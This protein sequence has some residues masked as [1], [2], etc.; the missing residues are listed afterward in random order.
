M[1]RPLR[2]FLPLAAALSSFLASSQRV[3]AQC[4]VV[5]ESIVV[6]DVTCFGAND[7]SISITVSGGFP[8]YNYVLTNGPLFISSGPQATNTF[9]FSGL[10]SGVSDYQVIVVGEDGI[11]GSCLG[12][13]GLAVINDPAPFDI[14]LTTTDKSC[15]DINDGS[16]SVVVT[17]GA[18]PYNYAW[19]PFPVTVDNISGLDSGT[20]D[21]VVTDA[22]GCSETVP[23]T[24]NQEPDWDGTLTATP[25]TC[26]NGSDG[27]ILSSGITGGTP[28]YNFS[29]S[30]GGF[31]T[32]SITD[33]TAG[34]YTLTVT[35]DI[36][37][38]F[39]PTP[40]VISEP[41]PISVTG[42]VTDVSC[43]GLQDGEIDLTVSG[44]TPPYTF[45]WSNGSTTEDLVGLTGGFYIVTVLDDNGCAGA[46]PFTIL[47]G[48]TVN[49]GFLITN[50]ECNESNG[51]VSLNVTGGSGNYS[52]DWQPGGQTTQ[53]VSGLPQGIYS[54]TVT[55]NTL[56]CSDDLFLF[57]NNIP[58]HTVDGVVTD[59]SSCVANDGAIDIT[60]NGGSGNFDYSWSPG[61]ETTQDL[62]NLA[63]GSYNVTVTDNVEGCVVVE[64]FTV[65]TLSNVIVQV[66]VVQ[67]SCG[68]PNGSIILNVSG[69]TDPYTFLWSNGSTDQNLV[70]V[71]AGIYQVIITDVNGC[72][73]DFVLVLDDDGTPDVTSVVSNPSCSNSAD[74]S[75]TLSL[76]GGVGPFT[77]SWSNGSI[78]QSI[79]NLTAGTYSVTILDEGTGCLTFETFDLISPAALGG[80]A[81]ITPVTCNG[82]A[83]G[84][85]DITIIGGTAPYDIVWNPGNISAPSISGL[86]GGTYQ[87]TITDDNGCQI[88]G[89][90]VVDEPA[91]LTLST[92]SVNISCD[93]SVPGSIDLNVS[94]GTGPYTYNWSNGQITEDIGGLTEGLYVVNVTDA[95]GC[96]ASTAVSIIQNDRLTATS[97]SSSAECGESNGSVFLDVTGGSGN[98]SF[99]W[100]PGGQTAQ[101]L[102]DVAAGIYTVT[103]TDLDLGCDETLFILVNNF[104]GHDLQ[105]TVT[106]GTDC[107]SDDGAI[108]LTINGGSG[109]FN[110]LWTPGGETTE[111]ISGLA[112]GSYLV[113]VEDNVTG[114]LVFGSYDVNAA[115][116]TE[117]IATVTDPTCGATDGSIA[118]S[119]TNGNGPFT[120]Q[121]S[122]GATVDNISG[123]A[124]GI[125]SLTVTDANGC[126]LDTLFTLSGGDAPDLT[127]DV[128]GPDCS[129]T[130]NGSIS[131]TP[132]G[133]TGPFTYQWS[134]GATSSSITNLG[135]GT[136][137]VVVTDQ[138]TGCQAFGTYSITAPPPLS[139]SV[140]IQ[141]VVCNGDDT[142]GVFV[143]ILGGTAPYTYL[144][145]P[146][147]STDQNLTGVPG[148]TYQV[149]VTDANGCSIFGQ[150]N[151]NEADAI[152]ISLNVTDV[153]CAGGSDGAIDM[154][155]NG[156]T[157]PFTYQWFPGGQTTEDINNLPAGDYS[158]VVTDAN[159]C[160]SSQIVLGGT[161][162]GGQLALPDGNGVS[163]NTTIDI[164]GFPANETIQTGTD[165]EEMCVNIEHSYL[166]DLE[167]RLICPS[168][169]S[170][171]LKPQPGGL[172]TY[173]GA[174]NDT[175]GGG[176][177]A[178]TGFDYCF[179]MNA[180]LGTILQEN[181]NGNWVTAGNPPNN[182]M[183]PGTYTPDQSFDN[184]IGCPLNGTWTLQVTDN[185]SIDDGFV[186]DWNVSFSGSGSNDSLAIVNEPDP[187]DITTNN[188]PATCGVCDGSITVS[189][190]NGTAP[191]TYLWNT[192]ATTATLNNICAGI[193]QVLVTDANGCVQ[194]F[195]LAL[196]NVTGPVTGGA[197]IT[198]ATCFNSCDGEATINPSGGTPPYTYQWVPGGQNTNSVSSLC[199]GDY[200]VQVQ[201]ADGC[202]STENVTIG[203]PP[204]IQVGRTVTNSTCGQC[205]GT[206]N[207]TPIAGPEP[208]SYD[209]SPAVV[210]NQTSA[211]DLCAGVYNITVTDAT[212]CE[213]VVTVLLNDFPAATLATT[214]TAPS[215]ETAC[216]GEATVT[217]I[218][219]TPPYFYVWND[220]LAQTNNTAINL[221]AGT[222]G[223]TVTDSD[224]CTSVAQVDLTAPAPI[225]LSLLIVDN[226]VCANDCDGAITV[227]PSGGTI[228]FTYL[229]SDPNGQITATASGLCGGTYTVTV[230]DSNGCTSDVTGTVNSPDGLSATADIT[231]ASC[232]GICDG[233]AT[234]NAIGGVPP[235]TYQ[236]SDPNAQT[237]TT[238]TG[239]CAGNYIV[240]VTDANGCTFDL[241]VTIAEPTEIT[242]AFDNI[243]NLLCDGDCIG[244]ATALPS[245]S[246]GGYSFLW[247]DI[248]TQTGQT[249]TG[250]CASTYTVTVT[251]ADGCTGQDQVTITGPGG[252]TSSASATTIPTCFG[253]CDATATVSV[254]GGVAPYS[255]QWNDPA[256]QTT[257]VAVGLCAGTYTVVVTD[258]NGCV[259]VSSI[260][261]TNPQ[262]ITATTTA[263]DPFCFGAC[264]GT[265]TVFTSGGTFPYTYQWSDPNGQTTITAVNLCSGVYNVTV[266]DINGCSTVASVEI[267]D[268]TEITATI[269][270]TE[271]TCGQCNGAATVLPVGGVQPYAYTWGDGQTTQ[272]VTGLCPGVYNVDVSDQFGC[273][274]NFIIP[275]NNIGGP[276]AATVTVNDATCFGACDGDAA[277]SDI[278]GGTPPYDILWVPGGQ[279]TDAVSGLCAGIYNVQVIDS[280]GCIYTEP[281]IVGEPPQIQANFN[282]VPS[283]CG[284]ANGSITLNPT[285]GDGGPY[286]IVWVPNVSSGTTA[287]DLAAG[288]YT[289]TITDGSNCSET[290]VIP[291]NDISGPDVTISGTNISCN[292]TCD[293]TATV[294]ITGGTAPYNVLW[295]DSQA[296]TGLTATG[297]CAGQYSATITDANGCTTVLQITLTEP[298]EISFSSPI[299]TDATCPS[300]CDGAITLVASGGSLPYTVVW[301]PSGSTEFTATGLCAGDQIATVTDANG[302]TESITINVDEP[303]PIVIAT[304]TLD[305][306][307]FGVCDGEAYASASG[308]TGLFTYLWNDL[309]LTAN[310]TVTS[311]CAGTYQVVVTDG[312]GCSDST[313]VSINEP[314]DITINTSAQGVTCN[315]DCDG[316]AIADAIGGTAPYTYQW[317]DPAFTLNDTV[318][319][320][321]PGIYNVLVT[322]SNGCTA[323][324]AVLISEPEL[325]QLTAQSTNITC[326][327]DCNG[328]A[329]VLVQGG[330]PG[331]TF[332]WNDPQA[333]T[334][335]TATGL[336]AGD[337]AV[338]VTDANGCIDSVS[339]TITEPPTLEASVSVENPSCGGVCD[340]SATV[341]ITGGTA[342]Y[343]ILWSNFSTGT[344]ISDLCAGNY[345]VLVTDAN[346]CTDTV[347]F[348]L[349]EP[350]VL[351]AN[352]TAVQQVLCV[353]SCT[354]TATVQGGGG[355]PPFSYQWSDGQT[356]ETATGLCVGEYTVT[357]TDDIGCT[358]QTIVTINDDNA[359]AANVPISTAVSCNGDCNGTATAFASGG[360]GPYQYT[361]EDIGQTGQTAVNLCPGAYTVTVIDVQAPACTTQASVIIAEPTVLEATVTVSD[362]SCGNACDGSATVATTGGTAPYTF[363][364]NDPSNQVGSTASSLC[365]GNYTVNVVDANGCSVQGAGEVNGPLAILANAVTTASSCSNVA[366]GSV[367]LTVS[368]GA[369]GFT[370]QWTPGNAST[371][372]LSNVPF[373]SYTVTITDATG[374]TL[375]QTFAVGT[376]VEIQADAGEDVLLCVGNSI[377]LNGSGGGSYLWSPTETLS[378]PNQSNPDARPTETT[379]YVLTVTIAGCTDSD[380]VTVTMYDVPPVDAGENVTIVQ[381]GTIGLNAL[382]VVTG[383]D[384]EWSPE[385][386]L[387]NPNVPNPFASPSETTLYF[388]TVTDGNGCTNIDS[389][390]VTVVPDISFPD[391]IS[392]NGDGINDEWIID[393]IT[394]FEDAIVEIYNRWGQL[395]WMSAP[396]YPVPWDGRYKDE[397]L[398]VGTYYYV[399]RSDNFEQPFTGPITIVR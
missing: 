367:N 33:V 312:A 34:T 386:G 314:A 189:P 364:W 59:G 39:I 93:G 125:Y 6:E 114:C 201:D 239:L 203:S 306:S 11:G 4:P 121:W 290:F 369:P 105:A 5:I 226:G 120:Y 357:V 147:G 177:P 244:E 224:G 86:A 15:P 352:I 237:D 286:S 292:G 199:P 1:M 358:A 347:N 231:D 350:P 295:N 397:D 72:T 326:G 309:A 212:G 257:P 115:T 91:T 349:S 98:Y 174:P 19:P 274:V 175:Q 302:C 233:E 90:F 20:Y 330:S 294:A 308:G 307:C 127:A 58:G 136:Y 71:G 321:C 145:T 180:P 318:T 363:V 21:L 215:C 40:V 240:Q 50:A 222:Y 97:L 67:P 353:G 192:G 209:W 83:D 24:I 186:F 162:G 216:D 256:S 392:P 261:V 135:Q 287:T 68:D 43:D 285:G 310:D 107:A 275:V 259:S 370:Y 28:P 159:G 163:Y 230:T 75:I 338:T 116:L 355:T 157:A 95:R 272:T 150:F 288:T 373:G 197:I 18:P 334:T 213:E 65:T 389:L 299:V 109:D 324:T 238:A 376:L 361:W 23:F 82:D 383:W 341:N 289:V 165:L 100:Q 269:N 45:N 380:S 89:Q 304:S 331:Y 74:G 63:G 104:P 227:I 265:S 179:S 247:D 25:V 246:A 113:S 277:I 148:G 144:W 336:C 62:N 345:T 333:Q 263:S 64:P 219:G 375:Q 379:T 236:W 214:G 311:L 8:D 220:P 391:G 384:Y 184:F 158:V 132:S 281:V 16:A 382:G 124:A 399:I 81:N 206:I 323:A 264:T 372:D 78:S 377:A 278:V 354:G 118:V 146:G 371:E 243:V 149:T 223:V 14:Q 196:N 61:N 252:F 296:Q 31:N 129:N 385:D 327:G 152:T 126:S 190:F 262:A 225:G 378:N 228:P 204:Q 37:C 211:I 77:F 119:V 343:V 342:D 87:V 193:Y 154:T 241:Q 346:L 56:G 398:P 282:S 110:I 3:L 253:G 92:T 51:A 270:V 329:T 322:D 12:V 251:D 267:F 374:C 168:G 79:S 250:L 35:D 313:T 156:G 70:N 108:D 54:V 394:L 210:G 57:V 143:N 317:D 335:A 30:P 151:I 99:D 337:Y 138:A 130:P 283:T 207:L 390:L 351:T 232:F 172:G 268:P 195:F 300:V 320:L 17:G 153:S 273:V 10:N 142:G 316:Q 297:L 387:D 298:T 2:A 200:F 255:Y 202:I 301:S 29:W 41:P 198:D 22:N 80:S 348:I 366:D 194:N 176:E 141:P 160:T 161:F 60:V 291:V 332:L 131:I 217:A 248:N 242:V 305:A 254:V 164:T 280:I 368:G 173:L 122:N 258:A 44:G 7:G 155:V 140:N 249:A 328:T 111:D 208:F 319:G 170:A 66:S 381:G 46:A 166:G 169:Q 218:G 235:Y 139:G 38:Q 137:S 27:A 340:G 339:V 69:G 84:A 85:I 325:L 362:E 48:S 187:I 106:D 96:V 188:T 52:Y 94:G 183:T 112:T 26:P 53:N 245:G 205:D 181:T 133:G 182:S 73:D 221:C 396:G 284:D 171:I 167:I 276:T 185:I 76:T 388:V 134:N 36:G 266:T 229:W 128:Q 49:I 88:L 178:G 55:D 32:E 360:V 117:L 365:V 393:N 260:V 359:L 103:I 123:L 315:G 271:A 13:I 395:L 42:V 344:T 47:D 303:D 234:V 102:T 9:T 101:N 279:T 293:G 191:Y 356:G